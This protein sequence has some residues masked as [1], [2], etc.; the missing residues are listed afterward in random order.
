MGAFNAARLILPSM[1][2]GQLIR[3]RSRSKPHQLAPKTDA[4]EGTLLLERFLQES[5]RGA[6]LHRISR[7]V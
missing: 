7:P 6:A 1:A 3:V 2:I 4:K 5:N